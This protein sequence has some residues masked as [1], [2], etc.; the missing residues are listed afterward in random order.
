MKGG[1]SNLPPWV[2]AIAIVGFPA[3]VAM[4]LLGM[5]PFLPSP[6]NRLVETQNALAESIQKHD[7]TTREMLRIYRLTCRGIWRGE[8]EI[9]DQCTGIENGR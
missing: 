1:L 3:I 9:Q 6:I 8:P 7:R 2:Q 4:F 5:L